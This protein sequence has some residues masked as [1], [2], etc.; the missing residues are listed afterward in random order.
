MKNALEKEEAL[1]ELGQSFQNYLSILHSDESVADSMSNV[2]PHEG[3][4]SRMVTLDPY[5]VNER[6]RR[7]SILHVRRLSEA[8]DK[9]Q[10]KKKSNY[11]F[12]TSIALLSVGLGCSLGIIIWKTSA[13][14]SATT[15]NLFSTNLFS[16]KTLMDD[17][18][19]KLDAADASE[20]L[21]D[22]VLP[23]FSHVLVDRNRDDRLTAATTTTIRKVPV[24]LN[25]IGTGSEYLSP[26]LSKCLGLSGT[27]KIR[28]LRQ[29]STDENAHHFGIT[30]RL[31]GITGKIKSDD[32]RAL[33]MVVMRNPVVRVVQEYVSLLNEK[34]TKA[35]TVAEYLKSPSFVDNR[36]TRLL[37]CKPAG[38][39]NE[40]DYDTAKFILT[41]MSVMSMYQD[42]T[43]SFKEYR[44]TF[45]WKDPK[46]STDKSSK[47]TLTSNQCIENEFLKR[48]S[49]TDQEL[50]KRL[51]EKDVVQNVRDR[52]EFDMKL[53]LYALG[54]N[55]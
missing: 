49:L 41:N 47:P 33:I 22:V 12:W 40:K 8:V 19:N 37:I 35:R 46:S 30:D 38:T 6:I 32:E 14:S 13:P 26:V 54:M 44:E 31:C 29:L 45:A 39:I 21:E 53:Y 17:F 2:T 28:D 51:V 20:K 55:K 10:E 50:S 34:E 3:G 16:S 9:E 15:S 42:Y 43:N 5:T 23:A 36:M 27:T 7:A 24:L 4:S 25:V 18:N 48:A 1:D 52:N 11:L